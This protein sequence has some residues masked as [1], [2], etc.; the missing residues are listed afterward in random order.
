M[1]TRHRAWFRMK[2]GSQA[3][4]HFGCRRKTMTSPR[5]RRFQLHGRKDAEGT[6]MAGYQVLLSISLLISWKL[7]IDVGAYFVRTGV[8][9]YL[10]H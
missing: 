3:S 8:L 5:S 2:P 9:G 10:S 4:H 7:A 1:N 6:G